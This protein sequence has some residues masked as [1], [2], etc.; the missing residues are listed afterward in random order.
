[1]GQVYLAEHT[2]MRRLV[3]L[4]VLPPTSSDTTENR[5][6]RERFL[7]EARAAATLDHPNIVRVFDLCQEGKLLYLVM[8][9]VEGISLQA[10]V[11]RT[12]P[13]AVAAA[14]T[15]PARWPS[16]S[17]TPTRW[18]SSTG[19]SSPRTCSSTAPASSRS[20]TSG[21]SGRTRTRTPG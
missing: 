7:R 17:S 6:A 10:L 20:S 12:G 21:W 1:M 16:G 5:I 15:T 3:A 14:A 19:T 4:K 8:E 2:A 13:L 18:A 11:A 9:Y